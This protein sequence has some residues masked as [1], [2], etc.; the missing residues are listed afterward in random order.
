MSHEDR[1]EPSL[2]YHVILMTS[3][4]KETSRGQIAKVQVL[5]TYTSVRKAKNAAHSCLFDGG[6]EREWFPT[7][8]TNP[9]VLEKLAALKGTG[10]VLYALALDGTEFRVHISTSPN[11]LCLTSYNEDGRVS[12]SLYY[13]VQ[14]TVPYCSHE[15]KPV[16]EANIEGVFKTYA[17]ARKSA[18]TLLLSEEDGITASSYQ[19]YTEADANERDCEYGENVIVHAASEN[20]E[21]YFI[22]VI[23]CQELES[24]RLA[25]ASF[26]I[27]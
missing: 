15:R 19:E 14:I 12:A 4:S 11:S 1:P 16:Y 9:A 21:N 27:P 8:E 7:F 18:S 26:R 25:E 13:V 17:E 20:G 6:Y 23:K 5:G 22:S 10:L 2:I 3:Q 24:V